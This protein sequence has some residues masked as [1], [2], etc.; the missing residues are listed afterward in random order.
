[1]I[2]KNASIFILA[3]A[4]LGGTALIVNPGRVVYAQDNATSTIN[5]DVWVEALKAKHPTLAAIADIADIAEDRD[6]IGK[7]KDLDAKEAVKT[8]IAL[9]IVRD[10]IQYKQAQ[11]VQ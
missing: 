8:L 2:T 3:V 1:M 11:E 4:V 10:L 9:N 7:L 5:T 6:V